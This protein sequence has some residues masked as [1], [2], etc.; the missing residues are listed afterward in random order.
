MA[1][2]VLDYGCPQS[3]M[4][5]L[6]QNFQNNTFC[7]TNAGNN[8]RLSLHTLVFPAR[9]LQKMVINSLKKNLINY[10]KKVYYFLPMEKKALESGHPDNNLISLINLSQLRDGCCSI[11]VLLQYL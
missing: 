2:Q 1:F 6:K 7:I 9:D 8:P 4:T 3:E 5:I 11:L 10:T